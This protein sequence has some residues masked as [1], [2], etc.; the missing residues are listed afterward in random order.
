MLIFYVL[1]VCLPRVRLLHY[2]VSNTFADVCP[3]TL[4][5]FALLLA[6]VSIVGKADK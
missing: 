5:S 3:Q 1:F 6:K 4:E 2:L